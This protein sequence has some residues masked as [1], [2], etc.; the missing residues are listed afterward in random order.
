[1]RHG[2]RPFLTLLASL[3]FFL[4]CPVLSHAGDIFFADFQRAP[5]PAFSEQPYTSLDDIRV[6][7]LFNNKNPKRP[8]GTELTLSGVPAGAA[9]EMRFDLYLVGHWESSGSMADTFRVKAG[10]DTILEM[11]KFPC[12]IR[13]NDEVLTEGALGLVQVKDHTLGYWHVP[14][15]LAIP[16]Q[17]VKNGVLEISFY[18]VLS[19]KGTEFWALDNVR[20]STK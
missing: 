16:P 18:G 4:L 2:H 14:V 12:K 17:A 3:L 19:G 5:N 7:G 8:S 10:G 11:K 1:M 9:L 20:V 13:D 15:S 6:L